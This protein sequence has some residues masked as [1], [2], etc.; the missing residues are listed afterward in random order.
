MDPYH[1]TECGLSNVLVHG[2]SPITDDGGEQTYT[3]KNIKGLHEAIAKTIIGSERGM[4]SRELRFV[5]TEMGL[6]QDELAK[7]LHK[8]RQSIGRWERG[9]KP[10]DQNA[11]AV[12]RLLAAER[13]G[14]ELDDR[15]VE[16]T[17]SQCVS[18]ADS[19]PINIDGSDPNNY[20]KAA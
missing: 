18:T 17:A 2:V 19:S 20:R 5:R 11:E 6:T 1:Y 12:V 14:L 15:S 10:I 16:K 13:L 9:E 8:D 7:I 3:I 4:S